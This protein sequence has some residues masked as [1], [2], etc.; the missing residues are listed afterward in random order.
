MCVAASRNP[1]R[2][3]I[4]ALLAGLVLMATWLLWRSPGQVNRYALG[5]MA[6]MATAPAATTAPSSQ[7]TSRPWTRPR[8]AEMQR[9]RDVMVH[10]QI[11]ARGI[12]DLRVL[13]ALRAV[14]RHLL[15]PERQRRFAHADRPLPIGYGQTIS[16]PYIV[17]LMS[18]L[19]R[20]GPDAKVLE[21]GT[22]SGYQAAVL[23]ELTPHVYS[24][25]ILKPL[26]QRAAQSLR[27]LGY[28]TVAVKRADG[29]FGWPEHAPFD[30]II[31]T[32]A[33][34][35]LPPPLFKQLKPGGRIVIP[36]GQPGSYQELQVVTKDPDSGLPRFQSISSVVF[37]PMTGQMRRRSR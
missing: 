4:I 10:S 12:G 6:T 31:V 30:G 20:L 3:V 24:I 17:A 7:P 37:V 33:A 35:H 19:L 26:A 13:D 28:T 25:E 21:I 5:P 16:Q 15:I 34:G 8:F 29:Y 11:A 32:C 27:T 2:S 23:T 36:I 1:R 14:P 9:Q 18:E 22:G